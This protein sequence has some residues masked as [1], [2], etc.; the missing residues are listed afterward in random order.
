MSNNIQIAP[1]DAGTCSPGL[2]RA[3]EIVSEIADKECR[4]AHPNNKDIIRWITNRI[5]REI[6]KSI[7][8]ENAQYPAAGSNRN[9]NEK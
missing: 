5:E 8:A 3:K 7:S 4:N 2:R 1:L 9:E 6:Q